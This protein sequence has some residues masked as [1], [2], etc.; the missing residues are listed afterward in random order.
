[1]RSTRSDPDDFEIDWRP[2]LFAEALRTQYRYNSWA[3]RHVLKTA[4]HLTPEQLLAPGQAGHGSVRDTLLHLMETQ[5]G[6]LSWW[7]GSLTAEEAYALKIAPAEHPD[8]P[9]LCRTW[10]EIERQTEAF[11]SGLTDADPAR[12]YRW[13]LP[14][15]KVWQMSLWGMMAHIVNHGTQHRAEV[16]AMLTGFGHSPGDLDLIYYLAR[17]L[18]APEDER[19][20]D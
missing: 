4:E 13:E 9:A 5:R 15:G 18:D 11:T 7:D 10:A 12:I 20:W 1:V 2:T 8:V 14:D 17:P 6:W 19:R 16:A 3:T